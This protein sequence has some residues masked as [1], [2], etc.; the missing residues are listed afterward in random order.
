[1]HPSLLVQ[2]DAVPL[3]QKRPGAGRTRP[4][5]HPPG[6]MDEE[7]SPL[8]QTMPASYNFGRRQTMPEM[9]LKQDIEKLREAAQKR[10]MP[11]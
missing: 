10:G 7:E 5:T 3:R 11:Y 4:I 1:M 9:M 2:P 8:A 6:M